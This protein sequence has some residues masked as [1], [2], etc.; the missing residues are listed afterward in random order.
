MVIEGVT[1]KE[2]WETGRE[3]NPHQTP[4]KERDVASGRV[5]RLGPTTNANKKSRWSI[6]QR[7]SV[8]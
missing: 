6:D 1:P 7:L 8:S 4:A 2:L 3:W 5:A